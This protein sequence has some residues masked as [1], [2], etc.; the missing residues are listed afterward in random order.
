MK[1][2]PLS[3]EFLLKRGYCCDN[4]CK[5][6]PYKTTEMKKYPDNI[7]YN[8]KLLI[9]S[10]HGKK[11]WGDSLSKKYLDGLNPHFKNNIDFNYFFKKDLILINH[12]LNKIFINFD[13]KKEELKENI[14]LIPFLKRLPLK[15]ELL[16]LTQQLKSFNIKNLFLFFY[17]WF[18]RINL[19]KK[20]LYK[21]LSIPKDVNK[22][23]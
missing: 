16:F 1:Y 21:D 22:L 9:S 7:E 12:F 20:D 11:W 13:Y 19:M 10:Y 17:Y 5:N 3:R 18:K 8:E 6:C 15:I 4:N 14:F 2:K 23:I